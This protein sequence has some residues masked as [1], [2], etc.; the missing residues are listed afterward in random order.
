VAGFIG[1]VLTGNMSNGSLG[2]PAIFS[3]I[4]IRAGI[5]ANRPDTGSFLCDIRFVR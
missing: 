1:L 4:E 2:K 5:E 3:M